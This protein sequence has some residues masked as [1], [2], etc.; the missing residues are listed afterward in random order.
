[1]TTKSSQIV[2]SVKDKN[3]MH[4]VGGHGNNNPNVDWLESRGFYVFYLVFI[5]VFH[6]ILLSLPFLTVKMAWTTTNIIHN[7]VSFLN[8]LAAIIIIQLSI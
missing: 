4:I 7:L 8:Q 5:G 6:L 2:K 3:K 1:V